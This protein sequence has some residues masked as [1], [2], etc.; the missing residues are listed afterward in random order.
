MLLVSCSKLNQ[1]AV[2]SYQWDLGKKEPKKTV[3]IEKVGLNW[4]IRIKKGGNSWEY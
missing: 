2:E 4:E 1:W 3:R